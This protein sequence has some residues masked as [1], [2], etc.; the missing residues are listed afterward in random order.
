MPSPRAALNRHGRDSR[1]RTAR[2]SRR[3]AGTE[4]M[5]DPP[6]HWDAVDEASDESFPAS[7]SPSYNRMQ[8][9]RAQ[10]D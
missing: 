1:A 7:D 6:R 9:G 2:Q 4:A 10:Q 8:P 5:R 3:P